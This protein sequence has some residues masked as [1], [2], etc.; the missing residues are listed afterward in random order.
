MFIYKVPIVQIFQMFFTS[1]F[2]LIFLLYHGNVTCALKL[3]I[4]FEDNQ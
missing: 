1:D 2:H 4:L 3:N